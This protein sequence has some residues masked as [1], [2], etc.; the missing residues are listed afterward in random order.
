M[1]SRAGRSVVLVDDDAS[2]RMMLRTLIMVTTSLEVVGEAPDGRSGLELIRQQ[3]PDAAVIDGQ[4]PG[5]DGWELARIVREE[6]PQVVLL[7][8]T[9][10]SPPADPLPFDAVHC[11]TDGPEPLLEDLR[12]RLGSAPTP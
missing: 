3:Q 12:A 1:E 5:L 8:F 9:G 2:V 10:D 11:K 6:R 4:M 7:M